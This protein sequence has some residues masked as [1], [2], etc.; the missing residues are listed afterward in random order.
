MPPGLQVCAKPRLQRQEG[1]RADHREELR[2]RGRGNVPGRLGRARR[3][4]LNLPATPA[5]ETPPT[6][7]AVLRRSPSTPARR[8]SGPE[9]PARWQTR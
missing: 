1:E 7:L 5:D 8:L 3:R 2:R 6:V 9:L 4:H